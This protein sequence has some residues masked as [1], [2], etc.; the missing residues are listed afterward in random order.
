MD[1]YRVCPLHI[2]PSHSNCAGI[3][4][5]VGTLTSVHENPLGI[6]RDAVEAVS[7]LS[8]NSPAVRRQLFNQTNRRHTT[9]SF[10]SLNR[11][12]KKMSEL[13][14]LLRY[15]MGFFLV[16]WVLWAILWMR[17]NLARWME[18]GATPTGAVIREIFL[19]IFPPLLLILTGYVIFSWA[20]PKIEGDAPGVASKSQTGQALWNVIQNPQE[21]PLFGKAFADGTAPQIQPNQPPASGNPGGGNGNGNINVP[22]E[23]VAPDPALFRTNKAIADCTAGWLVSSAKI[24]TATDGVTDWLPYGSTWTLKPDQNGAGLLF[25]GSENEKWTLTSVDHPGLVWAITGGLAYDL[26]AKAGQDITAIGGTGKIPESCWYLAPGFTASQP[27]LPQPTPTPPVSDPALTDPLT[28]QPPIV[29]GTTPTVAACYEVNAKTANVRS[30]TSTS[31]STAGQLGLYDQVAGTVV[32]GEC[33]SSG[34]DWLQVSSGAYVNN[35]V[36]MSLLQ[37]SQG[38]Q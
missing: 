13:S 37:P 15:V 2:V 33:L 27:S 5:Y 34:C 11:R 21:V 3:L 22:V 26:G 38:C 18:R 16:T 35:Y 23:P 30:S 1:V 20:I 12:N 28:T 14:D 31:S 19:T 7:L 25:T 17:R 9:A 32:T 8:C 29:A 36:H 10:R 6:E 24:N 4:A